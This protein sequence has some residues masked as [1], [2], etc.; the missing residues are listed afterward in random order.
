AFPVIKQIQRMLRF[1]TD[2]LM[3]QVDDFSE[4]VKELND[5]SWRLDKKESLFLGRV[6]R[7]HKGLTADAPFVN[8]IEEQ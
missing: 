7:L 2:E 8:S 5:Y 1:E 4:F 6:L 3:G